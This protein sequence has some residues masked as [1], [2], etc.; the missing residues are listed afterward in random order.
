M[1]QYLSDKL[2]ILSLISILLVLYIHSTYNNTQNDSNSMPLGMIQYVISGI[3]GRCA[4][5]IFY[6]ISGYLFFLNAENI[7][8]VWKKMR[9]RIKTLIIPFIIAALSYV[10]F[11]ITLEIIPFSHSFLNNYTF[12][13]KLKIP[14]LNIL[15]SLFYDSGDGSPWA[16]HL[17]Y[18][19]DLIILVAF[20]PIFYF[21]RK[22]INSGVLIALLFLL[23]LLFDYNILY[24]AFWFV[25]GSLLLNKISIN[26]NF[27]S[28]ITI[29][30]SILIIS[31]IFKPQLIDWTPY[32]IMRVFLGIIIIWN[33]YD[34]FVS[35]DFLLS[36]VD[37]L[38]IATRYTFFI[39][40]FHE[41][42]LNIIRKIV[43]MPFGNS[44]VGFIISYLFSPWI[45]LIIFIIIGY[46]IQQLLPK[47]Y[48]IIVGGR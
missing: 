31:Q 39:Y 9:K 30:F 5:P 36:N 35:A 25:T 15:V 22:Y 28:V 20:C 23:N 33:I 32:I 40:L 8:M 38:H 46:W 16:F 41:P 11:M 19:R 1:S 45:L 44:N 42:V 26:R 7:N 48:K 3:L 17:W 29:I 37:W 2:R 21:F 27:L 24:S 10:F 14:F 47:V 6:F 12:T 18:L 13:D 4:V 43:I 34:L